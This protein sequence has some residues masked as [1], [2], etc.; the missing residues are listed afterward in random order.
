MISPPLPALGVPGPTWSRL[1]VFAHLKGGST[2]STSAGTL[3]LRLERQ[4]GQAVLAVDADI[5]SQTLTAWRKLAGAQ[6]PPGVRLETWPVSDLSGQIAA[7]LAGPDAPVHVVVDTGGHD[8]PIV[9]QAL[10]SG[11]APRRVPGQPTVRG[12]DLIMPLGISD[13]E[14]LAVDSTLR[15]AKGQNW[16]CPIRVRA[17]FTRVSPQR[18]AS[19]YDYQRAAAAVGALGLTS[20]EA[21]IP[22]L[23]QH[24]R[25]VGTIPGPREAGNYDA[26]LAE[27]LA[28]EPLEVVA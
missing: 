4:T 8:V 27:L 18:G 2:K 3:A 9:Q 15:V 25:A 1:L 26:V 5:R 10:M 13:A 12:V 6:W 11:A 24:L 19:D 14:A 21:Y 22:Y 16:L 20:F 23:V 17:L 7:A 28:D